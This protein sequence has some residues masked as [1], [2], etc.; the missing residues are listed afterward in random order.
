MRIEQMDK[1]TLMPYTTAKEL[2]A[3]ETEEKIGKT[4]KVNNKCRVG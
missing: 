2:E 4:L 3:G 1:V